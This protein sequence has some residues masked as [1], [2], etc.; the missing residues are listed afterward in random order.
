MQ[1]L[2]I[3]IP[4]NFWDVQIYRDRLHLWDM[5]GNLSTYNWEESLEVLFA[6]NQEKRLPILCAFSQGDYLYGEKFKLIFEDLDFKELLQNKFSSLQQ[7]LEINLQL[8][9]LQSTPF[10]ELHTDSEIYDN[11]LYAITDAGLW[12][13]G[14]HKNGTGNPVSSRPKKIWDCNLQSIRA[15]SNRL[16]LSGGSD[17]LF[18]HRISGDDIYQSDFAK[19]DSKITQLSSRH[20]LYSTWAFS[21]IFNTSDVDASFLVGNYWTND[22]QGRRLNNG[23]I[24]ELS[25]IFEDITPEGF[26]WAENEK[27]YYAQNGQIKIVRFNQ[28]NTSPNSDASPFNPVSIENIEMLAAENIIM[29]DTAKFGAI[30]EDFNGLTILRSDGETYRIDGNISRWRIYPRSKRYENHLHIILDDRI[31]IYSFNH[32]YFVEQRTKKFGIEHKEPVA[33]RGSR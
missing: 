21:S 17:G 29:A 32:D 22:I 26:S 11:K 12:S 15:H 23:N 24:Y 1:P 33:F 20:S 9:G 16:A 3:V 8:R 19:I 4:G 10:R 2:K 27:I 18:E 25:E 13:T 6:Q 28:Q 14:A 5:E 7:S 30:I 31:E